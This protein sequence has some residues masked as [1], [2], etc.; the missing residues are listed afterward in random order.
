MSPGVVEGRVVEIVATLE[1]KPDGTGDALAPDLD[2]REVE[3]AAR[4]ERLGKPPEEDLH[5]RLHEDAFR[6]LARSV[7]LHESIQGRRQGLV[8]SQA[9]AIGTGVGLEL[10]CL[11]LDFVT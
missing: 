5:P 10:P 4:Q 7:E 3:D 9:D 8:G 1:A 2:E 11:P 6:P